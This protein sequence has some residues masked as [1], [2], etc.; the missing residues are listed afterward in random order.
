LAT[1]RVVSMSGGKDIQPVT[2]PDAGPILKAKLAI[3]RS[4]SR[5]LSGTQSYQNLVQQLDAL[6]ASVEREF[7]ASGDDR[8]RDIEQSKRE[9][10][11]LEAATAD[12][13]RRLERDHAH[14]GAQLRDAVRALASALDRQRTDSLRAEARA[15]H[16]AN[17]LEA[18]AKGVAHDRNRLKVIES[19]AADQLRSADESTIAAKAMVS[20]VE[21]SD[22][23]LQAIASQVADL[24][25]ALGDERA[26]ILKQID[27]RLGR[28]FTDDRQWKQASDRDLRS[29][30][31]SLIEALEARLERDTVRAAE[32]RGAFNQRALSVI[33]QGLA[34][35]RAQ[36]ESQFVRVQDLFSL[37]D[38]R[39]VEQSR[40]VRALPRVLFAGQSSICIKTTVG[41]LLFPATE[42][43][44]AL[45]WLNPDFDRAMVG[46][47]ERL[48]EP[49]AHFI[50]IGSSIGAM[51]VV[52][53]G[54]VGPAGSVTLVDPI[55]EVL[56][57]GVR[58]VRLNASLTSVR[59]FE[60]AVSDASGRRTLQV[61]PSD[62][63]V[64][65]IHPYDQSVLPSESREVSLIDAATLLPE[66][67]GL[68]VIKIDAEAEDLTIVKR[69]LDAGRS[70]VRIIYEHSPDHFQR[71]GVKPTDI[72]ALAETHNLEARFIAS[73]G[74]AG[75]IVTT[76][77][78]RTKSGNVQ[79]V[80]RAPDAN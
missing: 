33:E 70:D 30:L 28:A 22:E 58:N 11:A 80:L 49:G 42:L 64:S 1:S 26:E 40:Q 3:V 65:T 59:Q 14:Q 71:A 73:D 53:A 52:A 16:G 6:A 55:E 5:A 47:V 10:Q 44:H 54:V 79:L 24:K 36:A 17:A 68:V 37:V 61:F 15:L 72:V 63:R 43:N 76:E 62:T 2:P 12:T 39:V 77:L 19:L 69:L 48:C 50:D 34:G 27:G 35:L 45:S 74:S 9:I 21:R 57:F 23:N 18:M 60:A 25:V 75:E 67:P 4:L 46:A 41:F 38:T 8:T 31:K 29:E 56:A 66:E 7:R 51:S 32:E 78:A 13:V 20:R